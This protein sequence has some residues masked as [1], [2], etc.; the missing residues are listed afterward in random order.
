LIAGKEKT[1]RRR[2]WFRIS[3]CGVYIL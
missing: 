1:L 3:R 2:R